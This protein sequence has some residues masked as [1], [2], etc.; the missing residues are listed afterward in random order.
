MTLVTATGV[1]HFLYRGH[2]NEILLPVPYYSQR[3]SLVPGQASRMCYSSVNAML[4]KFLRPRA[5]PDIV[6]AD[7]VYLRRVLQYGDTTQAQ[8]QLQALKSYGVN[9]SFRQNLDWHH[10][11]AQLA[12]GIPVPIGILHHGPVSAPRGSGHWILIIGR[13]ADG[14]RYYVHDPYG[15][16][17]LVNGRYL[18]SNG[19]ALQ[20]SRRN[21]GPRWRVSG[22]PGWGILAQK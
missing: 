19:K 11:D 9:A 8:A 20:Y 14:A 22:S 4:L 2:M 5:L 15:D 21:L 10:I 12:L 18:S 16:L 1:I 6:S 13:T 7:D 3:D 17:D